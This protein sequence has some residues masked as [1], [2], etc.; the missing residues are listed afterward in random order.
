MAKQVVIEVHKGDSIEIVINYG[1]HEDLIGKK[2]REEV[3]TQFENMKMVKYWVYVP[4]EIQGVEQSWKDKQDIIANR[5]KIKAEKKQQEW[6]GLQEEKNERIKR[7][8]QMAELG[9]LFTGKLVP[10]DEDLE[11]ARKLQSISLRAQNKQLCK[12]A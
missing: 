5:R 8:A 3:V 4:E 1:F 7:Y 11:S 10:T 9:E 6:I 12:L 2:E